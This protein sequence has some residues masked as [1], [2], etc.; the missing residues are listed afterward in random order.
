MN[1]DEFNEDNMDEVWSRWKEQFIS[2]MR[3]CI[4]TVS[5]KVQKSPPWLSHDLLRAVRLRNISYR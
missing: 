2:V 1:V 3:Q 4:P 5:V